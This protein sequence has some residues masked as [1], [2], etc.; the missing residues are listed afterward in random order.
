MAKGRMLSKRA[1]KIS[2]AKKAGRTRKINTKISMM[3]GGPRL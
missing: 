2:F 3:R 1:N